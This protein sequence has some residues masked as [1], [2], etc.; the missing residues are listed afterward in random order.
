[1]VALVS[2]KEVPAKECQ[3]DAVA[4]P[5]FAVEFVNPLSVEP[6]TQTLRI[7]RNGAPVTGAQV[8]LRADMG[9]IGRM[10]GMGVS[11]V[12]REAAP[13]EYDV[14]VRFEMGGRWDGTVIVA[15]PGAKPVRIPVPIEVE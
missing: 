2:F 7:T 4:D 10:S 1:V 12:A 8:C 6:T 13:G 11:D 5:S 9:G 15:R 3:M 14:P